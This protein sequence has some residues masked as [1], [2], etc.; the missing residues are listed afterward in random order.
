MVDALIG[1]MRHG[2]ILLVDDEPLFRSAMSDMLQAEGFEVVQASNGKEALAELESKTITA[3]LTDLKMP[4][5]DGFELLRTMLNRKLRVPTIVLSAYGNCE[6]L[7]R[8]LATGALGFVDKPIDY[9]LALAKLDEVMAQKPT[10]HIEGVTLPGLLQLV[11]LEQKTCTLYVGTTTGKFGILGFVS[12]RLRFASYGK[13]VGRSAAK[14]ISRWADASVD[15][16]SRGPDQYHFDVNVSALVMEAMVEE[17]ELARGHQVEPDR[18]SWA[19][20]A[21]TGEW[22]EPGSFPVDLDEPW[23]SS[24]ERKTDATGSGP[25]RSKLDTAPLTL[26]QERRKRNMATVPQSLES[27]MKIDGAI[28]AALVD[29]KSGLT[30]GVIGG[31]GRLDMELAA[32]AN[33]QVVRAKMGAMDILGIPGNITDILITLEDQIH[34]IRPL[35]RYPDL[36]M[37]IALDK[38]KGNLGLARARTQIVEKELTL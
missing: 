11:E 31:Q 35:K 26:T 27:L 25:E 32:S 21:G 5:M 8:V 16:D 22:P 7:A 4:V 24:P 29:W 37:Y 30:L 17:D 33:T 2:R 9:D 34:I 38:E 15:I 14:A 18:P 20:E 19:P 1:H 28:G 13:R 23:G 3:M 10:A 12:G 6:M 36:F